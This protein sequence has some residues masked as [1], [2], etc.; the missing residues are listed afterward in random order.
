MNSQTDEK[1]MVAQTAGITVG[2]WVWGEVKM[3]PRMGSIL[4]HFLKFERY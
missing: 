2:I 1:Y 3:G 4:H